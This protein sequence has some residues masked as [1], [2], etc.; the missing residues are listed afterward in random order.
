[1]SPLDM[2][3]RTVN[4]D[5]GAALRALR[6]D[7]GISIL[8][9]VRRTELSRSTVH[10]LEAGE[11]LMPTAFTLDQLIEGLGVEPEVIYDLAL[12]TQ[13]S[14]IGLPSLPTYFRSKYALDDDQ[15][16]ELEATLARVLEDESKTDGDAPPPKKRGKS[17]K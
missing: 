16:S 2:N 12:K 5:F 4:E 1:M 6:K 9:L 17:K 15:I 3:D 7:V 14:S 11:I 8:E 10:R 13:S